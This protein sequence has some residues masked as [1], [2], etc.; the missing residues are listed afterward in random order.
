MEPAAWTLR[1]LV[2][3]S[4]QKNARRLALVCEDERLT[5]ADVDRASRQAA[6]DLR[7]AGVQPGDRVALLVANGLEYPVYDVAILR[8]GAV[9]IPLNDMLAPADAAFPLEHSGARVLV[10]SP[11][12]AP[13]G[14]AARETLSTPP[15]ML[16]VKPV[17]TLLAEA[18]EG[19]GDG[20][21]DVAIGPDD[22][23]A[24][25]YTGGTTGKP[26]AIVHSQRSLAV[27]MLATIVEAEIGRDERLLLAT[28]LPHAAGVFTLAALVRGAT[29]V[30]E[31]KFD[32]DRILAAIAEHRITWTFMVPTMIYRVLDAPALQRSDLRSLRTILYGAAPIRPD[33]LAQAIEVF[34]PA[35]LQLYGQTECPNFATTLS[36]RDHVSTDEKP[37]ILTSCGRPCL[38]VEVTIRDEDGRVLAP[39]EVGEVCVRAPY[40]M[41]GYLDDPDATA[42]RFFGDWLRTGDLGEL[43]D[44]G[45]LYLKDRRNDMVIS[46]GM[47][48]Y[49]SMVERVVGECQGVAQAAVIG[50]P[51]PDWGEAVH[52]V[53][54]V[55]S[56][57]VTEDEIIAFCRDR[58][59]AYM[60]PKS[61]EIVDEMPL[62]P[63]G[64]MD[65]KRL[66]AP[67]WEGATRQ[68]G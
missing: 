34:G 33:R 9:K 65:K 37:E 12:L 48:V 42:T 21:L 16:T 52:A 66:R 20:D 63:Y 53:V 55:R 47:N 27:N 49:T 40:T 4:L 39:G 68:I 25:Y 59:A 13:L 28:P 32:V 19:D 60:R 64:K 30:I 3:S 67:H 29:A 15:P 61:V 43:D 56:P 24:I 11:D 45:Y 8:A 31:R 51:D 14:D 41:T 2:A 6:L 54:T 46:G 35:F 10:V 57:D 26:K 23:A 7:A 36:K 17:A 38:M 5:Y 62:T 58:L 1:G 18:G 44:D 50:I 22:F